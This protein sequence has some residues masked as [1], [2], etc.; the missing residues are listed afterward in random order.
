M[1][2]TWH[3]TYII[4]RQGVWVYWND[5]MSFISTLML[6]LQDLYD[7]GVGR[8]LEILFLWLLLREYGLILSHTL[9]DVARVGYGTI[10]L[11]RGYSL[12]LED[13]GVLLLW[14]GSLTYNFIMFDDDFDMWDVKSWS[15]EMTGALLQSPTTLSLGSLG[16]LMECSQDHFIYDALDGHAGDESDGLMDGDIYY[17][18]MIFLTWIFKHKKRD[19]H[20]AL[21]GFLS[22]HLD[23]YH[24]LLEE[25]TWEGIQQDVYQHMGRH[26]AQM[27]MERL[28]QPLPY[29]FEVRENFQLSHFSSMKKLHGRGCIFM[30]HDLYSFIFYELHIVP[31]R[32]FPSFI[33]YCDVLEAICSIY[34]SHSICGLW[35]MPH[36]FWCAPLAPSCTFMIPSCRMIVEEKK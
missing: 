16:L 25:F 19:L 15:Y 21:V 20:V 1:G 22:M 17:Q 24:S 18:D 2:G 36:D 33:L 6:L 34:V 30:I 26:I 32:V 12:T 9:H 11:Q 4:L 5:L 14:E 31:R 35:R 29:S 13:E 27:M 7:D 8:Q 23:A 28:S 3:G 10:M